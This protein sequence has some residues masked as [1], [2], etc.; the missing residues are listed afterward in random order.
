MA[1]PMGSWQRSPTEAERLGALG[2][3]VFVALLALPGATAA[4]EPVAAN[5][6]SI[7]IAG[8][9]FDV[10]RPVVLWSDPQGFDAYQTRCIDQTGGC[11]DGSSPRFG[12]RKGVG[13]RSLPELREAISQLVL[14]FDG[15]VNSRSC[16]K[17][18][19]NRSRPAG[20]TGCGLSAHFMI[21]ADGTIYQTLDLVE[22]AFHAE[23]A[24][25]GSVGVEI[26]NRGKV[27]RAEWP[28]LPADYRTRPEK[29]VVINGEHHLA[30]E[31]RAEQ[32]DSIISLARTL[33]RVFPR[34]R[35][36]MPEKDG[37][38]LM[39]T[40]ADPLAFAGIL[41]HLHVDLQKQKWDPGALDW[42]RIMRALNGFE[43]P[44][45]VRSFTEVPKSQSDW[46]AARRAVFFAAEERAS[47][48]FPMASGRL[49]H[50]GVHLRAALGSPVRAP[51][52]GR[53]VA[54]RRGDAAE[55]GSSRAFVL[56]R[57]ELTVGDAPVTFYSLLAHLALP[58]LGT[59]A[60]ATIP[61]MQAVAR[62]PRETQAAFAAGSIV[63]LDERAE[64]GDLVGEVGLVSRGPE[65]G[66]EVHFE[67]F[68]TERLGGELGRA[69]HY[70]NAGADGPLVRRADIVAAVDG[71]AD[72]EVDAAELARFFRAGDYDK[73]QGLRTLAV[74]HRHEWGDHT[75]QEELV[76]L[77]ELAG[78]PEAER[79]RMYQ[80]AIAP[81]VFWTDDLSRALG[82]PMNQTIVSYNPLTFLMEI[83]ARS[84]GLTPPRARGRE[85]SDAS[86][87]ARKLTR[88]PVSDWTKPPRSAVEP[89]LFG[90]PVGLRL[91]PKRKEDIPLIELAPTDSR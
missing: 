70:V 71:N 87:E 91:A 41:G 64:A 51:T 1:T 12:A 36:V 20:S 76:G 37:A 57:H 49:W 54:V 43:L 83:A 89:P 48:F 86:L 31:F 63:T 61:W 9:S 42:G 53:I 24:N 7:V 80:I 28:K 22:R 10:G 85:I 16:F 65:Q 84:N 26:C 29:D 47:G 34:I 58:E 66:P 17:S 78:V 35:P 68:T 32:Y 74:R 67:I 62:A 39:D 75:T 4:A 52:R 69:F 33:L 21:D 38:P 88:V 59:A 25:S 14:H 72:Q 11:C 15:C 90:P 19:H 77:R 44:V 60:A 3:A 82:L 13:E 79:A 50:S 30:Y 18:M 56:I 40:L 8:Q 5:G 6:T 2:A 81:Y 73:R 46:L 27:D 45:Q 55:G 23:E